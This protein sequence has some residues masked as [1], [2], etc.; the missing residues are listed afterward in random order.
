MT[1]KISLLLLLFFPLSTKLCYSQGDYI[2]TPHDTLRGSIEVLL[3]SSAYEEVM[4]KTAENTRRL[5]AYQFSEFLM[6]SVAYR[7]V[8]LGD[9]YRIMKV[10]QDGYLSLLRFRPDENYSFGADY[11]LKRTGEGI[12]V[13]SVFFRKALQSF[14]TDCDEIAE[15]VADKQYKRTHLSSLVMDYNDCIEKKTDALY[16]QESNNTNELIIQSIQEVQ[17][18]ARKS[19]L[20]V[21]LDD[22]LVKVKEGRTIPEYMI[23][24]LEDHSQDSN[25]GAA[26]TKLVELLRT[27][28]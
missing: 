25:T 20:R 4:I 7:S 14:L 9:K 24:A 23:S 6:D 18:I 15:K 1:R 12:E 13:P 16:R 11:L 5:K 19:E 21:L 26:I 10:I 27:H 22:I 8:K 3:P 2:I 28:E 17:H